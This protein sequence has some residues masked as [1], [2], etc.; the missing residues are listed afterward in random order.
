MKRKAKRSL[1][2]FKGKEESDLNIAT[3]NEALGECRKY[4]KRDVKII[5]FAM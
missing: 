1:G 5:V 4:L 3:C 2:D